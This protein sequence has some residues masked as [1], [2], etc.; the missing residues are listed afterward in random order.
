MGP[1]AQ[2]KCAICGAPATRDLRVE[3]SLGRLHLP[4]VAHWASEE[5]P[6]RCDD[7]YWSKK[8]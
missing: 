6:L 1:T 3:T 4:D 8:E 5:D 7:C 2:E